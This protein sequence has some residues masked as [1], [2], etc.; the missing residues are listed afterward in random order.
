M[1]GK[2][3]K[4]YYSNLIS[5]VK[6]SIKIFKHLGGK[7]TIFQAHDFLSQEVI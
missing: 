4:N 2:S 6:T 5:A 7:L 3:T 1:F